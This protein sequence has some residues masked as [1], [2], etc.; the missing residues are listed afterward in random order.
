MRPMTRETKRRAAIGALVVVALALLWILLHLWPTDTDTSEAAVSTEQARALRHGYHYYLTGHPRAAHRAFKRAYRSY[1]DIPSH[2]AKHRDARLERRGGENCRVT[3]WDTNTNARVIDAELYSVKYVQRFCWER[4][5]RSRVV[6]D[7][8]RL[9][10]R[11]SVTGLGEFLNWSAEGAI[12]SSHSWCIAHV[13][14]IS[15][16]E[17]RFHQCTPSGLVGC[18]FPRDKDLWGWLTVYGD[19][20]AKLEI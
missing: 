4:R 1:A 13:C 6:T 18:I 17:V 16:K 19:G 5:G 8:S 12:D 3:E 7:Y 20:Q 15:T 11:Q 9:H 14:H 10:A 2:R